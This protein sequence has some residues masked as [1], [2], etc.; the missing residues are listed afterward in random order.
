MT[1]RGERLRSYL[2]ART[3]GA[4]GWQKQ[5]VERAG[6]KRQTISKWTSA[7]FDGYPDLETLAAVAAALDVPTYELIAAMEGAGPLLDLSTSEAEATILR[8][9]ERWARS[10]GLE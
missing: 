2:L 10:R 6:V 3:G 8:V 5:L 1:T 9:V 7:E 4:S